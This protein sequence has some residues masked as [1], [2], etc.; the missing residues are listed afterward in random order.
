MDFREIYTELIRRSRPSLVSAPPICHPLPL[1]LTYPLTNLLHPYQTEGVGTIRSHQHSPEYKGNGRIGFDEEPE[2]E[3]SDDEEED[4][5][6]NMKYESERP[7]SPALA[8]VRPAFTCTYP[9]TSTST[10]TTS[11][12][13]PARTRAYTHL[14][15]PAPIQTAIQYKR[16]QCR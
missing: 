9:N 15:S 3:A 1:H 7:T 13:S 14:P 16:W 12:D 2:P 8:D 10:N 11:A 4:L 6:P 5:T